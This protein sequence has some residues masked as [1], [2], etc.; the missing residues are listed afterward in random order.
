MRIRLLALILAVITALTLVLPV[1]LAEDEATSDTAG[2]YYVYTEN[3]KTLNVR[4]TPG[5]E[6]VGQLKYGSRVY[7]YYKDGGNGWALIDYTYDMP[8]VGTGTYACFVSSRY[9]VKNKPAA[10]T[11]NSASQT[12]AAVTAQEVE[13]DDQNAEFRSAKKVEAYTVYAR[14]SR[15]SGWVYMRWAPS[16]TAEVQGT[17]KANSAFV[18]L[19]ELNKWLQVEDP[20]TGNIG[21]VE[22]TFVSE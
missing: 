2:H 5:G 17:Y 3:G 20:E 15:V 1:S 21:F 9:L 22:K 7:C 6:V 4:A 10:R 16:R 13:G 8:G 12:A 11:K 18:V 19:Q 14:P